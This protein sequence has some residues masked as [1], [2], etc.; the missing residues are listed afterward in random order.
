MIASAA[1]ANIRFKMHEQLQPAAAQMVPAGFKRH[2]NSKIWLHFLPHTKLQVAGGRSRFECS[3]TADLITECSLTPGSLSCALGIQRLS[4]SHA[5]ESTGSLQS[6]GTSS[7]LTRLLHQPASP[8]V[9]APDPA[10]RPLSTLVV[11]T[12]AS[13]RSCN[14]RLDRYALVFHWRVDLQGPR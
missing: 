1:R 7:Q 9:H 2:C 11:M 12:L 8:P 3:V 14:P 13:A 6:E 10:D 5:R 4:K